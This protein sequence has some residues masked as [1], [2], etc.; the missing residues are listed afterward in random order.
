MGRLARFEVFLMLHF[1][2]SARGCSWHSSGFGNLPSSAIIPCSVEV[3]A[4]RC[5]RTSGA[6]LLPE[7]LLLQVSPSDRHPHRLLLR[8]KPF[9]AKGGETSAQ[10]QL[11]T[12]H[13][14]LGES[15]PQGQ[16]FLSLLTRAGLRIYTPTHTLMQ[17][18][19]I[20]QMGD[21][22]ATELGLNRVPKC[23]STQNL[24]AGSVQMR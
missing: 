24:R 7:N 22:S 13:Q 17:T 15:L 4:V 19:F 5:P 8:P 12:P 16:R 11:W 6:G 20:G 18:V 3:M 14:E 1:G 2:N 10:T 9:H 23:T 21:P